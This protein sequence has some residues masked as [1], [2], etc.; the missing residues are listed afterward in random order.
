MQ[1]SA[2]GASSCG[3]RRG[4]D[5]LAYGGDGSRGDQQQNL[6][7]AV[8][9]RRPCAGA[10]SGRKLTESVNSSSSSSSSLPAAPAAAAASCA[11]TPLHRNLNRTRY[12]REWTQGHQQVCVRTKA[13]DE[14]CAPAGLPAG[15]PRACTLR[16][17]LDKAKRGECE[18][19]PGVGWSG[20]LR[21]RAWHCRPSRRRGAASARPPPARSGGAGGEMTEIRRGDP[22]T[23]TAAWTECFLP[24][25]VKPPKPQTVPPRWARRA[26]RG[27][28]VHGAAPQRWNTPSKNSSSSLSSACARACSVREG[29]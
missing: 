15:C 4:R 24:P 10:C 6:V 14:V 7:A 27:G 11:A 3:R 2:G 18:C 5:T 25:G 8:R 26:V 16:A 28:R 12:R 9:G 1:F 22:L 20:G 13:Y 19:G 23:V 17:G 21:R 29:Q